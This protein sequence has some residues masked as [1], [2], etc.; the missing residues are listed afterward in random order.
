[1][2]QK[3][4]RSN[5][6]LS[7]GLLGALRLGCLLGRFGLCGGLL[8]RG[9]LRGSLLHAK[10]L[11]GGLLLPAEESQVS[12]LNIVSL[13]LKDRGNRRAVCKNTSRKL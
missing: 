4:C 10:L 6:L 7:R 13:R 2:H 11:G 8:G 5:L 9:L 12:V 1:M 3:R